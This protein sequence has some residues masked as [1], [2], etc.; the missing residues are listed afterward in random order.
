MAFMVLNFSGMA[1]ASDCYFDVSLKRDKQF[2]DYRGANQWCQNMGT[3]F[4][5]FNV[6]S[7]QIRNG[8]YDYPG[9][10]NEYPGGS[11]DYQSDDY[12]YDGHL[13]FSRRFSGNTIHERNHRSP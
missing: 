10:Y 7:F 5:D 12:K 13:N 9:G 6:C 11:G 1:F 3:I 2:T 4:D 8:D